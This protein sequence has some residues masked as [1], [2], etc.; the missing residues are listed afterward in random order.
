MIVTNGL[1][2]V[3]DT[4]NDSFKFDGSSNDKLWFSDAFD[5]CDWKWRWR[6]DTEGIE[7][8]ISDA[9]MQIKLVFIWW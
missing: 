4:E 2:V 5:I 7:C 3:N 8:V 9:I 6:A 1:K